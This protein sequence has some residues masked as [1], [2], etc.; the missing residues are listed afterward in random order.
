MIEGMALSMES[1]NVRLAR[2]TRAAALTVN[3]RTQF[4]VLAAAQC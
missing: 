4:K 2:L 1:N 3:Q